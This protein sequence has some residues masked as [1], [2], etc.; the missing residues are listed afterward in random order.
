MK[1]IHL[2]ANYS[3]YGSLKYAY[4]DT[5]NSQIILLN[6][7]LNYGP[8]V[9]YEK[10]AEKRMNYLTKLHSKT[11]TLEYLPEVSTRVDK[12]EISKNQN[13][14]MYYYYTKSTN[15]QIY[16][17]QIC[18]YLSNYNIY[19]INVNKYFPNFKS[20]GEIDPDSFIKL[21]QKAK[22]LS[23]EKIEELKQQWI[24]LLNGS[25]VLRF[26]YND[27]IKDLP[28]SHY[29]NL[30]IKNT[31]D[32]FNKASSIVG[33]TLSQINTD[34]SDLFI[35]YRIRVLIEQNKLIANDM[36]CDLLSLQIKRN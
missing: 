2:I 16:L 25:S 22:K 10:D 21:K 33:K 32:S 14:I 4:K 23:Q 18:N 20:T 29:D 26:A 5:K 28:E 3:G 17:R 9:D 34:L 8:I 30:I 12:L 19:F 6:D 31:S 36:N 1:E 35:N 7:D 27:E 13:Y 24:D 11:E 15:E